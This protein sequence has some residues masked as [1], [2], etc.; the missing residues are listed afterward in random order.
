[1]KSPKFILNSKCHLSVWLTVLSSK[2]TQNMD[3]WS[4]TVDKVR[5]SIAEGDLHRLCPAE[6]DTA[7]VPNPVILWKPLLAHRTFVLLPF[8]LS[9]FLWLRSYSNKHIDWG[10]DWITRPS[11]LP[12]KVIDRKNF[13][14]SSYINFGII[15]TVIIK[16]NF[17]A[18]RSYF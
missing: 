10:V 15:Y 2:Q 14:I 12:C 5:R 1:M 13:L 9:L 17:W 11:N 8:P 4:T 18:V 6:A 16:N 3:G 7:G